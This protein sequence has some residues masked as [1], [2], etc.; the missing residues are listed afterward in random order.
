M[1][2]TKKK[3]DVTITLAEGQF[4][5]TAGNQVKLTGLR[6]SAEIQSYGGESQPQAQLRVFGVPLSIINQITAI[7]PINSAILFKN[8]VLVEAGDDET[9][10]RTVYQGSIW[11]AWGEFDQQPYTPLNIIGLGGLD[12]SLAPAQPTS[13]Q[14]SADV[15]ELMRG[16]ANTMGLAF[17]N[18][19]VSVQLSHPYLQGS[20]MNQVKDCAEAADINYVI[21][22]GTLA[23]WPSE[24]TR[25]EPE[26]PIISPTSGMVGYPKF[27]SNGLMVSAYFNPNFKIGGVVTVESQIQAACGD[28]RVLQLGHSLAS[29]TPGGPWFSNIMGVPNYAD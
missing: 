2:L 25:S 3:I 6:V 13:I 10:M 18:N 5:E 17:E 14:G 21:D 23:I 7:G 24:G 22:R 26:P 15:A 27:A 28:W 8:S 12:Y 4:G 9:G 19:G 1:S 16:F 11:Q 20:L 29:E